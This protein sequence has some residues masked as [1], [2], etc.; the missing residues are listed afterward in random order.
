MR[1]YR[2]PSRHREQSCAIT[3]SRSA[4]RC[5]YS[6]SPG[7]SLKPREACGGGKRGRAGHDRRR[8]TDRRVERKRQ[9]KRRHNAVFETLHKRPPART[10][11][12]AG[13]FRRWN[14]LEVITHTLPI[15][16]NTGSHDGILLGCWSEGTGFNA[17]ESSSERAES[18]L[19][20]CSEG[21]SL[22]PYFI[23]SHAYAIFFSLFSKNSTN[24]AQTLK[25]TSP[26]LARNE[27]SPAVP[28]EQSGL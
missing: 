4:K 20:P 1:T 13:A 25:R 14:A 9:V 27:R 17:R 5:R 8:N 18:V 10:L 28:L 26:P 11:S 21:K 24:S 12:S 16:G 7:W 15:A 19:R 23:S 6:S 22:D 2:S 3:S